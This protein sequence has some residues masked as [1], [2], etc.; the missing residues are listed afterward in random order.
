MV[1]RP[2]HATLLVLALVAT[3]LG[4]NRQ[5]VSAGHAGAGNGYFDL[6]ALPGVDV[7]GKTMVDGLDKF[8]NDFPYRFTGGPTERFAAEALRTEMAGLGY[9]AEIKGLPVVQGATTVPVT[10]PLKV[11]TATKK[12]TT[13]PD[14]W[15]L[16]VGHYDTIASTVYGAYDN[17]AGTSLIR[18]L[19]RE[20]A[21]VKTN[22]SVMFAW[23]NAEEEG[24][25]ASKSHAKLLKDA[26]TKITAVLGF[27]MPGIAWP[28]APAALTAK[29]CLCMFHGAADGAKFRP[30]LEAVNFGYLGYPSGQNKVTI[31][32]NNTRNSDEQSFAAQGYPT[33][34]W[35]G[36]RTAADYRAYHAEDDTMDTI[37]S[38]AGGRE[39]F[40][41]G[42]VNTLRS[43]Y[44]TMLTLDNHLPSPT[45]TAT[46]EG[47][48]AT[49][50]SAGSTDPDG[51]LSEFTWDFGDGATASGA[52]PSH[53]YAQPG[54]YTVTL[55]AADNL[56]SQVTRSTSLL[57]TV[58]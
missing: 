18:Y 48:T 25:L 32:G 16:F 9:T 58:D 22:R 20:L 2:V 29:H 4:G 6:D 55:T 41:Q 10:E 39:Y 45:A 14:E 54:T 21:D 7:T 26:G 17:G 36:M 13:R 40:E 23:Y 34:R 8:V 3:V 5:P 1:K 43:A 44:Y 42:S 28:V 35:A 11:V 56:W 50:D 53:T 24:L 47:L 33:M 57:V 38:V 49:F 27:D 51:P 15:I 46:V 12:G 30:L 31:V 19:A 37:Y 52:A